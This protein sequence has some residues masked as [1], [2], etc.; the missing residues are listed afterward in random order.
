MFWGLSYSDEESF[1]LLFWLIRFDRVFLLLGSFVILKFPKL[2]SLRFLLSDFW[3]FCYFLEGDFFFRSPLELE[4]EWGVL[5][6]FLY[7]FYYCYF[8]YPWGFSSTLFADFIYTSELL[9]V[10]N[11]WKPAFCIYIIKSSCKRFKGFSTSYSAF[12]SISEPFILSYFFFL[13]LLPDDFFSILFSDF[14]EL[15][16]FFDPPSSLRIV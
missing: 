4:E 9:K 16:V 13:P 11:V 7:F 5:S 1:L 8:Y 15:L 6:Y 10:S 12:P 3:D 2:L 14:Y